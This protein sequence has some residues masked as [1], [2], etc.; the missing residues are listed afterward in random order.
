MRVR[1]RVGWFVLTALRSPGMSLARQL[2]MARLEGVETEMLIGGVRANGA[3]L[4]S[5]VIP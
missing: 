2:K 1:T 5:V 4:V 3:E